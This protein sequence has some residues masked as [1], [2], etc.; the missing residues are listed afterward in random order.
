M[1]LQPFLHLSRILHLILVYL[2]FF[3]RIPEASSQESEVDK[4]VQDEN[5]FKAQLYDKDLDRTP[6]LPPV[7]TKLYGEIDCMGWDI[8]PMKFYSDI[9]PPEKKIVTDSKLCRLDHFLECIPRG[10][11]ESDVVVP[12][13]PKSRKT[14]QAGG[15]GGGGGQPGTGGGGQPGTGG[16][17]QPG[18]GGDGGAIKTDDDKENKN[19][20][21]VVPGEGLSEEKAIPTTKCGCMIAMGDKAVVID[22][23]CYIPAGAGWFS[24][25]FQRL[26]DTPPEPGLPLPYGDARGPVRYIH[27]L[28]LEAIQS[29]EI[30]QNKSLS[31]FC[32][33]NRSKYR[34]RRTHPRQWE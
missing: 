29:R 8:V 5:S 13:T 11:N 14:R 26:N 17:G 32:S 22:Q 10:L 24:E 6:I 20:K 2:H 33:G 18:T 4:A 12:D 15:G 19:N 23:K 9:S 1:R 34:R 7:G 25:C 16:G 27:S 21:G 28:M 3:S 31:S 30:G